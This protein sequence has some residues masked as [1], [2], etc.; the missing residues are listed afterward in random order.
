MSR[1]APLLAFLIAGCGAGDGPQPPYHPF[2]PGSAN[3]GGYGSGSG[4]SG[5]MP[6]PS[7]PPMCSES[8][9]R[10]PHEFDYAGAGNE[11]SVTLIG[12]FATDGWTAGAPM[13]AA[14][15][16]WSVSVPVPWN[17]QV[18]YKFHVVFMDNT[19]KY[20]AD[21]T[22]PTQVDDGFGGKNSVLATTTCA[23]WTCVSTAISCPGG[24]TGGYDWRDAVMY[25]VFVDRFL[26]GDPSNNN[27]INASG[28]AQ[29][30]N[31]QGGDWAGVTQKI[32]SGYFTSL[33]V[34]TL[35][36]SVPMDNSESTGIGDDGMTYTGYH[37]YWP[38]NLGVTE[39]RFGTDMELKTLVDEAHKAGLKILIDYAMNHVHKDSPIYQMHMN[40]GWFNPLMVNGQECVCGTTVC[41]WDGPTAKVCWFRDYLP[42]FNFANASA[43]AYSVQ[44]AI[45]WITSIGFDGYRLD[46]IK[47]VE[48]SWLT[49]LR[50]RL[51][52][53]I[54]PTSKQHTYL[55][56]ETFT[57]DQ[58]LI[59]SF[60][61]PCKQL[62]GQFDFPLRASLNGT[63]LARQGKMKDLIDFMDANTGYYGTS[64]MSTFI[65]NHDV[66]RVIHFAEDTP[67]WS[68][69]WAS[70]KDRAWT[71]QPQLVAGTSAYERVALA[72][73]VLMTNRGI[74]LIYYGDEVGMP[75]AGDP[76][77]RRFMQWSGYSAGQTLLQGKIMKLGASRAAH[78]ALRRGNRT[79]VTFDDDSWA[80]EM[81]DGADK[82]FVLL[83]RSDTTK[84][85]GGLPSATLKD[86]ITGEMVTGPSVSVP[87][88]S[89]RVL[90]AP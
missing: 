90:P 5:G 42:D 50:S 37:G 79:T 36:L 43:R 17:G 53:E 3:P 89:F 31:W 70:G 65:G 19:E 51:T 8:E 74:P 34:N 9:R 27:P 66:P 40:D 82:V 23:T 16:K 80:Y 85:I 57:G 83:N 81:V 4:G 11:K 58:T 44:N 25:F 48:I 71:N 24:A 41:P 21:P 77:N 62:D 1:V 84:S 26:D 67:Q 75:G 46:A 47:H 61:D 18:I 7:G 55:V 38:R 76:D 39:A 60:I 14:G 45:D 10:C 78:S 69:I 72:M 15:N 6:G 22:N 20:L 30:A 54:E 49:D 52:A 64:V 86:E 88:R 59:K 13:T 56:G 33:G 35:W 63:V 28:L 68:D 29:A 12:D 87:P 32:K 73:A 2:D